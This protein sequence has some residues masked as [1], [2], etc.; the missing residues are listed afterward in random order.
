M[1]A[2][3]NKDIYNKEKAASSK[4]VGIKWPDVHKEWYITVWLSKL[5]RNWYKAT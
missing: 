4:L 2:I 3:L 5:S 1:H